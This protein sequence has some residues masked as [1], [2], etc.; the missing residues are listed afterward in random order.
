MNITIKE[1]LKNLPHDYYDR[2]SYEYIYHYT[3][4]N[5][6][7]G[8]IENKFFFASKVDFM[9][10]F[11]ELKY[12]YDLV[13]EVLNDLIDETL[14]ELEQRFY[15]CLKEY[16]DNQKQFEWGELSLKNRAL[17][18]SRSREYIISFS[19]NK[20]SLTLWSE[21]SKFYGYNIGF[22]ASDLEEYIIKYEPDMEYTTTLANVIYD[23]DKQI[24]IIENEIQLFVDI[25]KKHHKSI[26]QEEKNEILKKFKARLRGYGLF[27]KDCKF[28]HEEEVRI[29]I[30]RIINTDKNIKPSLKIKYRVKNNLLI[31]YVEVP[32]N[33]SNEKLPIENITV[34]SKNNLSDM[35]KEG[36]LYL[37]CDNEYNVDYIDIELS[38]VSI[39]Y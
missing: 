15:K 26:S 21:Y 13:I 34:G 22:K 11:Y 27:F 32:Y 30:Y 5:G 33:K 18:I 37:L 39:R 29:L 31:P 24:R 16:I 4:I 2:V 7:K 14:C 38:N 19:K 28:E 12:S 17:E 1:S 9:N 20:D 35:A 36:I 23:K 25:F 8:I 10:D 6:L 3:D